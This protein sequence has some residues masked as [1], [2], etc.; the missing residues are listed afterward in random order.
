MYQSVGDQLNHGYNSDSQ[1]IPTI[2][3]VEGESDS[4]DEEGREEIVEG[5]EKDERDEVFVTRQCMDVNDQIML[6]R[7]HRNARTMVSK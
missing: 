6:Y 4:D 3:I 1:A 5:E 7:G 2:H